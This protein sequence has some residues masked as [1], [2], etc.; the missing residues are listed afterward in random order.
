MQRKVRLL[1]PY[2]YT[3]LLLIQ[4]VCNCTYIFF[5]NV[6]IIYFFMRFLCNCLEFFNTFPLFLTYHNWFNCN[7]ANKTSVIYSELEFSK[8]VCVQIIISYLQF[9]FFFFQKITCSVSC[10]KHRVL[11]MTV[12]NFGKDSLWHLHISHKKWCRKVFSLVF[13]FV[14]FTVLS[15][16]YI[17]PCRENAHCRWL[18][19]ATF[20]S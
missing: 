5:L 19:A 15:T 8:C 18:C 6:V 12:R 14:Q 16:I 20:R 1:T 13:V 17:A 4:F 3:P 7:K 9:F 11:R 2:K 10:G